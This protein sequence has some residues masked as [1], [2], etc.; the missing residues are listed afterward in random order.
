MAPL[1]VSMERSYA[2]LRAMA[3]SLS[4]RPDVRRPCSSSQRL[5]RELHEPL[6]C[7]VGDAV[8]AGER[9]ELDRE[10]TVAQEVAQRLGV[11][12]GEHG[13]VRAVALE[14][15]QPLAVGNAGAP[16]DLCDEGSRENDE[17]RRR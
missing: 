7:C 4:K 13:V 1:L 15:A 12:V 14:N 3:A 2:S 17:R 10:P 16:L 11:T 8:P 5:A 9:D 6:E